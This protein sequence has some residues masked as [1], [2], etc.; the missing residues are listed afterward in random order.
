LQ[1]IEILLKRLT[2]L[3][4]VLKVRWV[5][6]FSSVSERLAVSD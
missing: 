4:I 2:V 1:L 3:V 5:Q 6:L